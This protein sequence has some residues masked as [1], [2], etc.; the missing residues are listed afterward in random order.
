MS[1]PFQPVVQVF[2]LILSVVASCARL[3]KRAC[4]SSR[5]PGGHP[6]PQPA[7]QSTRSSLEDWAATTISTAMK[8]AQT[9]FIS[10]LPCLSTRVVVLQK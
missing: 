2:T 10:E 5:V 4:N 3:G 1:M 8:Q 9:S 6:R 7:A